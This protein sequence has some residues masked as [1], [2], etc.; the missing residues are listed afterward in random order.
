MTKQE[1][2]KILLSDAE[3]AIVEKLNHSIYTVNFLEDWI[4]RKDDVFTNAPA[5]LQ[6]CTAYGFYQAI[7][8]MANHA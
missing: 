1:K 8:A 2:D 6:S 4:N 3:K 5:A 7:K